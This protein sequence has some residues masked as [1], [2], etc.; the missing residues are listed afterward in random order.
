MLRI[1]FLVAGL[2]VT[3]VFV[4]QGSHVFNRNR[5]EIARRAECFSHLH[6]IGK[7]LRGRGLRLVET[8]RIKIDATLNQLALTCPSG[9]IVHDGQKEAGYFLA[10][11]DRG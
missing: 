11:D 2:F 4:F 8:N 7:V 3:V 6:E 1:A 5:I 9:L 10:K